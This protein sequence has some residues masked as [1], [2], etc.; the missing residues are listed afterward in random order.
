MLVISSL[1]VLN[2]LTH[3]NNETPVDNEFFS[4]WTFY[5]FVYNV[6]KKDKTLHKIFFKIELLSVSAAIWGFFK[7]LYSFV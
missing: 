6:Y 4:C 7:T 2:P 1:N 5:R 3:E